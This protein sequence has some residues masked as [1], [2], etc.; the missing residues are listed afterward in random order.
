M[1]KFLPII[2]GLALGIISV[3]MGQ[4]HVGVARFSGMTTIGNEMGYLWAALILTWLNYKS[5]QNWFRGFFASFLG[6]AIASVSYYGILIFQ[7]LFTSARINVPVTSQFTS[8][9]FWLIISAVVSGLAAT[10]VWM[11]RSAPQKW[12]NY[13]IFV[14]SYIGLVGV[15]LFSNRMFIVRPFS[16]ALFDH[17]YADAWRVWGHFFELGFAIAV[18]TILLG[19]GFFRV[20]KENKM[21]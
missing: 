7:Y 13:G 15:A 2:I 20:L 21:K 12:L 17:N 10:A 9:A 14:V 8:L 11:A 6:L 19:I 3:V 16:I 18:S 1:R 5:R 4:I